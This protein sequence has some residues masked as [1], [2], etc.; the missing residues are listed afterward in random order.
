[1]KEENTPYQFTLQNLHVGNVVQ[2]VGKVRALVVDIDHLSS[3]LARDPVDFNKW[4]RPIPLT[5][6]WLMKFGFT[7]HLSCEWVHQGC[8]IVFEFKS[9]VECSLNEIG[10]AIDLDTIKYVHQLQNLYHALTG[11]ELPTKQ[12]PKP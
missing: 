1:M 6:D 5:E 8:C 10:Q 4:L 12:N 9:T 3:E 2:P 7:Q 11:E